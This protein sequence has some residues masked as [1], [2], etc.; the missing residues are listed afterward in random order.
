MA[1]WAAARSAVV[2]A[3]NVKFLRF[4]NALAIALVVGL[5]TFGGIAGIGMYGN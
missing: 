4:T 2:S 3:I 5:L 1:F